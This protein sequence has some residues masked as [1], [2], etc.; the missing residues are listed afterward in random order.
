MR[1]AAF[2][3]AWLA[4]LPAALV[5]AHLGVML[6]AWSS[7]LGP[8]DLLYSFGSG[9]PFSKIAAILTI[10][11]VLFK[12]GGR[13]F[14]VD[15][16]VLLLFGLAATA[17]ISQSQ[18]IITDDI[19]GGGW[20]YC[21]Q[22]LKIL[23]LAWFVTG[24]MLDRL[25]VHSLLLAISMGI[26]FIGVDEALKFLLSAGG[27]KI[28][29][30]PSVG[31]NNQI[32][33]DVL[34]IVPILI[35][36][37]KV[38]AH[39]LVRLGCAGGIAL[40]LVCVIA[41]SSRGAFVGMVVLGLSFALTSRRKLLSLAV[42]GALALVGSQLVSSSFTQ[43][44]GTIE[45][46]DQDE[47]FVGRLTA[48]KVT[49]ALAVEHPFFGGGFR[50][51]QH[52]NVWSEYREKAAA[53]TFPE[54]PPPRLLPR[55]AHSIYF[56]ALGDMGFVGLGLLLALFWCA[57]RNAGRVRRMVREAGR[58]DLAWAADLAGLLRLSLLVL[59]VSGGALSAT[60]FDIDYLLV[61]I[62]SV[63]VQI[64]RRALAQG[65]QAGTQAAPEWPVNSGVAN[66]A[67][68]ARNPALTY[69]LPG[70]GA[71]STPAPYTQLRAK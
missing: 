58:E 18:T 29:G 70:G 17:L 67:A 40:C 4:M 44:V 15:G 48:W 46:A 24:T 14:Y 56:E 62:L 34:L 69:A 20:N 9:I 57:W 31:D 25:R 2:L 12:R 8:N 61:A 60:Y 36:L 63:L 5:G 6:W 65:T 64:T 26:G 28:Q 59:L 54:T 23:L 39:R 11:L 38:S 22:F 45:E 55:A 16:T 52:P 47:S 32:G 43:R 68:R 27:H 37:F 50:A 30:T 19:D 33:M 21:F 3:L 1:D 71:R 66:A 7:L 13:H 51:I 35:H 42:V 41:S 49:A 10:G 53:F